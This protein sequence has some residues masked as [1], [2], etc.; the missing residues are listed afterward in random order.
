MADRRTC[1]ATGSPVR[2]RTEWSD[3]DLASDAGCLLKANHTSFQSTIKSGSKNVP[4]MF[5]N[6]LH[7][8]QTD[9]TASRGE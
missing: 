3:G 9:E 5:I 4:V 7:N 2:A 6:R 1:H 8:K